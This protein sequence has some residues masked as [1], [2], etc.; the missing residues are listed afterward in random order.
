MACLQKRREE[1]RPL[2]LVCVELI[3]DGSGGGGDRLAP[4][5][6]FPADGV[7]PA[8]HEPD[9]A[10]K[11]EVAVRQVELGG[12]LLAVLGDVAQVLHRHLRRHVVLDLHVEKAG[13]VAGEGGIAR[14]IDGAAHRLVEPRRRRVKTLNR[15]VGERE[16]EAEVDALEG[17]A[18][19]VVGERG[20]Q[21]AAGL[22][23]RGREERV[24]RH[25]QRELVPH[26]LHYHILAHS[27]GEE[28][29]VR[30]QCGD[31]GEGLRGERPRVHLLGQ[32][33]VPRKEGRRAQVAV[34]ADHVGLRV[35]LVV[36][37]APPRR[38]AA[39]EQTLEKVL[40]WEGE[41]TQFA[42]PTH[43]L[44]EAAVRPGEANKQASHDWV[45]WC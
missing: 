36:P 41:P 34:L 20:G 10:E 8:E 40:P 43:M 42:V 16:E 24:V 12:E 38:R 14:P 21:R 25:H 29:D 9:S 33:R 18:D 30:P 28:E 39:L 31:E 22:C 7:K 6:L 2:S 4:L 32:R 27:E 1:A 37:I 3:E 19:A 44:Q 45:R 23:E 17:V 11:G 13:D 5:E 35:V 15:K 26:V